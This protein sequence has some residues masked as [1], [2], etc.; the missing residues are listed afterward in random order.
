[1]FGFSK[2][3][4]F[5][6]CA[7]LTVLLPGSFHPLFASNRGNAPPRGRVCAVG[8]A[9]L[10]AADFKKK[11][12]SRAEKRVQELIRTVEGAVPEVSEQTGSVQVASLR[13]LLATTPHKGKPAGRGK[14][15]SVAAS[16][17]GRAII[18]RFH[19]QRFAVSD[20]KDRTLIKQFEKAEFLSADLLSAEARLEWVLNG[21][22]PETE[23]LVAAVESRLDVLRDLDDVASFLETKSAEG[24]GA[25]ESLYEAL[26]RT[27]GT[28]EELFVA[29][30]VQKEFTRR[31]GGAKGRRWS[32]E[33]CQSKLHGSF[34]TYR[35]YR[36]FIEA[37]AW[38]LAL[39]PDLP[40]P[41]NLA[42]YD[43]SAVSS[44]GY[45]ARHEIDI[46][47]ESRKGD[48]AAVIED[49]AEIIR[50]CPLPAVP[51]Q[52]Y[53]LAAEFNRAFKARAYAIATQA[54]V[55]TDTMGERNRARR[56]AVS[57]SLR[58]EARAALDT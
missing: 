55:H 39:P 18:Y 15:T 8:D 3:A 1:M 56:T 12:R 46:L 41:A 4:V 21:A 14:Q 9:A 20:P 6:S 19:D 58:K 34:L 40:L 29:D 50:A 54:G 35:Q 5:A 36:G 44:P 49:L 28:G 45:S 22:L 16:A 37:V 32:R 30:A 13:T 7:A 33:E 42:R 31:F 25:H 2:R 27:S 47:L 24:S 23:L 26:D 52:S 48:C 53:S 57:E 17:C 51:W 11:Y 38:S 43:Y 10:L